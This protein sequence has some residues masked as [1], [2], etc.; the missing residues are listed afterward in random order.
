MC[1]GPGGAVIGSACGGPALR[2]VLRLFAISVALYGACSPAVAADAARSVSDYTHRVWTERDGAPRNTWAIAQTTDGWLWF[3]GPNGLYRFDGISFERRPLDAADAERPRGVSSMLALADGTL[4]LGLMH[5]GIGM[6]RSGTFTLFD[7]EH[8]RVAGTVLSLAQDN[9]GALWAGTQAGLLRFDGGSWQSMGPDFGYRTGSTSI[10][11]DGD[12]TL[13][14]ATPT[15]ILRL[16]RGAAW[17]EPVIALAG[18]VELVQALDGKVWATTAAGLHLL[19]GQNGKRPRAVNATSRMSFSSMFD[20][21]GWYWN[22]WMRPE[23]TLTVPRVGGVTGI[24]TVKTIL[25]DRDGNLWLGDQSAVIHRLRRRT[26]TRLE[27]VPG[28]A[29]TIPQA[30]LVAGDAGAVWIA[31]G[32]SLSSRSPSDG[33]WKFDGT[34][35][36]V[37]ADEIGSAT[38]I[39]RSPDGSIWVGGAGALWRKPARQDRFVRSVALPAQAQDAAV[40]GVAIDAASGIWVTIDGVGLFRHDGTRWQRNADLD[41]LPPETPNVQICDPAGR[42]WLGYPSGLL[43]RIEGRSVTLFDA[44]DGLDSGPVTAISVGTRVLVGG[45]HGLYVQRAERFVALRPA[46]PVAFRAVSGIAE[47]PDGDVWLN[48]ARGAVHLRKA[49]LSAAIESGLQPVPIEVFDEADGFP[50]PSDAF[51]S[52]SPGIAQAADGRLWFAGITGIGLIDPSRTRRNNAAPQVVIVSLVHG[53]QTMEPA[54]ELLLP[55]GTRSIRVGYTALS[56]SRPERVRFRYRL[57]GIEENWVAADTRRQ[58]SY[59]N[60]G[61]GTY[62]FLVEATDGTSAWAAPPSSMVL[63][64]P[65]TFVQSRLF[66]V[67]CAT[68]SAAIFVLLYR[69]RIEHLK[70]RERERAQVRLRERERVARDLH[71][72]LLQGVQGLVLKVASVASDETLPKPAHRALNQAVDVA[73]RLITEGRDQ[74]QG[75]R[76]SG[77]HDDDLALSLARVRDEAAGTASAG[78]SVVTQ[79]AARAL[80]PLAMD[81]SYRVGREAILNAFRHADASAIEVE[82]VYGDADLRVYVRDDGV[83]LGERPA[84]QHE[85]RHWGMTGMAERAKDAGGSIEIWSRPDAGTEV[86]FVLDARLAYDDPAAA[87]W[88]QRFKRRLLGGARSL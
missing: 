20:A 61:P 39:A 49:D 15:E 29:G 87:S 28:V 24:G 13:W 2:A 46:D 54:P 10:L 71:D 26:V 23:L 41:A 45:Q 58:A 73:E 88:W 30:A 25:Q 34:L 31:L 21:E 69:L 63:V 74:I 82:I 72:T 35:E 4:L 3:A 51:L 52:M 8:T 78:F 76:S 33:I 81:V 79:G 6:L 77:P 53:E 11:F 16:E 66:V 14:V 36:H 32:L 62:R 67:L 18:T 38:A 86:R 27:G 56:Y 60:L 43:A 44:S 40:R 9:R 55:K 12:G 68:V 37:Q 83:G 1:S 47:R 50:G 80:Q 57:E 42:I 85:S 84:P 5:G 65:P 7:N 22:W 48:T 64:I 70:A 17:L 19:P 59:A 75:L